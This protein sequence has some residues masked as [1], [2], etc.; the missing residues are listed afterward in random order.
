MVIFEIKCKGNKSQEHGKIKLLL[1]YIYI[2]ITAWHAQQKY[3]KS[4]SWITGKEQET[5]LC[6]WIDMVLTSTPIF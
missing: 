4:S 3:H 5:I 2:T 6:S 1:I